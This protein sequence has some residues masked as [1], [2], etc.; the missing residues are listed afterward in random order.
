MDRA[1]HPVAVDLQLKPVRVGKSAK[2][3]LITASGH[4]QSLLG[5]RVRIKRAGHHTS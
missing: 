4:K 5:N 1:E 3:I 2:H